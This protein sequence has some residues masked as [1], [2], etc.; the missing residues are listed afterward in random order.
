M[1]TVLTQL[2]SLPFNAIEFDKIKVDA[3]LPALKEAIEQARHNISVLKNASDVNFKNFIAPLEAS[4]DSVDHVASIFYGLHSAHCT[5]ELDALS[6]QISSILTDFYNDLTLDL[7]LFTKVA[8]CFDKR[9]QD[10]LTTEEN[11]ILTKLYQDFIRNGAKLDD[12]DKKRLREIDQDLSVLGLDFSKN[13]LKSTNSFKLYINDENRL[14]GIAEATLEQARAKAEA[15]NQPGYCFGLDFPTYLSLLT[16][17]KDRSLREQ[18]YLAK[19]RLASDGEY[20]NREIIKKIAALRLERAK[21]LGYSTHAD[22]V[23]EERMAQTPSQVMSFLEELKEKSLNRAKEDIAQVK[24]L[25]IKDGLEDLMPWDFSF[26]RELLSKEVLNFDDEM[27]RPYLKLE[28][29]INGAFEV[30]SRLYQIKFTEQYDLP[31]YHEEVKVYRVDDIASGEY[32]GLFYAD[33]FPRETKRPGAWAMG[34]I[35]QGEFLGKQMRPHVSIVCNFTKPTQTKPSLLNLDEVKTLFHEF[36]H[37]MHFLLSKCQYKKLSGA[38]VY[39]D[40]VELPSQIMENWVLEKECLELFARHYQTNDPMPD[41]LIEKLKQ[42]LV[43][44]EGYNTTRQVSLALL[45]MAYHWNQHP[46]KINDVVE[47]E[48]EAIKELTLM[49]SVDQANTSCSFSHIFA[50]GYSSG[51]YS[52]KWAEVLDADAFEHFK[53]HGIFNTEIAKKFRTYVLEKGGTE[54]PAQMYQKFRG[55]KPQVDA[56]LK[57]AGL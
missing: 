42:S 1:N 39:W 50:G 35:P 15:E 43:F 55:Q 9:H 47:F 54:H 7:E 30:A 53:Q 52:Y 23:L 17:A 48:K 57:R 38:N 51:Y 49:P 36:G 19:A 8:E 46:E 33:F 44:M 20:D 4:T 27:L 3:F 12:A 14:K 28:N 5:E 13:V 10:I 34:W 41:D 18:M 56:L 25:A 45:D 11:M 6:E 26:Y 16:Y 32:I 2:S 40:F 37:A 21:L 24:S 29:V 31:T 22:Y